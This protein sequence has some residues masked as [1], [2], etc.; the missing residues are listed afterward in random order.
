LTRAWNR[1]EKKKDCK[2]GDIL[3]NLLKVELYVEQ[4]KFTLFT[5]KYEAC[6]M[7]GARDDFMQRS[8]V[9]EVNSVRGCTDMTFCN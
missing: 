5:T 3:L 1:C 9:F 4:I 8:F 6:M 7:E 2:N